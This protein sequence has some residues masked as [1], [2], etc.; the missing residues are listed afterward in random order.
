MS[1]TETRVSSTRRFS[2]DPRMVTKNRK[3]LAALLAGTV[4]VGG[5]VTWI[6]LS[7]RAPAPSGDTVSLAK[8]VSTAEFES[9]TEDR[10]RPYL[11]TLEKSKAQLAMAH[12]L[13]RISDAEYETALQ[14]AWVG[15]IERQMDD[16][17]ALADAAKR[18]R[19]VDKIINQRQAA[20]ARQA[21][22]KKGHGELLRERMRAWP[23]EMLKRWDQFRK[24]VQERRRARGLPPDPRMEI[25]GEPP[26]K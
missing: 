15:R 22:G 23:P 10:K 13:G 9:L 8:F 20:H 25:T 1:S 7:S 21:G 26:P 2:L 12:E 6:L 4:V 18:I 3:L 24:A 19:L 16:Y 14:N 17:L 11:E 5:L